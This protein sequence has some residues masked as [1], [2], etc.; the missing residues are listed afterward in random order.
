VA[1]ACSKTGGTGKITLLRFRYFGATALERLVK[2]GVEIATVVVPQADDRLATAAKA[3]EITVIVLDDPK[4]VP[5]SAIAEGTDLIVAA[6]ARARVT[7]EAL[8]R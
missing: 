6:H 3:A 7:P 8:A 5:A 2:E 1:T 4:I